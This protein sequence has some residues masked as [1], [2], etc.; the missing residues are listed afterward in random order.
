MKTFAKIIL[1]FV[2][3]L[4]CMSLAA[5]KSQSAPSTDIGHNAQEQIQI[6]Y[7]NLPKECKSPE[8]EQEFNLAIKTIDSVIAS[9]ETEKAPLNQQIRYQKV[10][11][12]GLTGLS[13][14]LFLALVRKTL[15]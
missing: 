1:W 7:N 13:L 5:C 9:C 4:L 6:V 8:R 12:F 10:L 15:V 14:L 2:I 11:L 3:V